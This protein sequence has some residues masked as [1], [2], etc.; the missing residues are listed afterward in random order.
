[1]RIFPEKYYPNILIG[2]VTGAGG[3]PVESAKAYENDGLRKID[4]MGAI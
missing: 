2:P 4:S 3:E 1:M